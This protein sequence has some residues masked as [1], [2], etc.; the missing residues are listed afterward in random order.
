MTVVQEERYED[1]SEA[2]E[3]TIGDLE[4]TVDT[5]AATT[6]CLSSMYCF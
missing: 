3:L 5:G 2:L 1:V 4:E 6:S